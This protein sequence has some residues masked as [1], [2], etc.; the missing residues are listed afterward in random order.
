[1]QLFCER[2]P[3]LRIYLLSFGRCSYRCFLVRHHDNEKTCIVYIF[4]H[5]FSFPIFH[6]ALRLR[7]VRE[8]SGISRMIAAVCGDETFP[9]RFFDQ[10]VL[11]CRT[12]QTVYAA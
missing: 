8:N 11:S 7:F 2:L 6:K 1:M 9:L 10:L 3:I 5:L 4:F 12:C